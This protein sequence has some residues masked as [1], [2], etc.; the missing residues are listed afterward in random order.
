MLPLRRLVAAVSLLALL[1]GCGGVS[2]P[3]VDIASD[4]DNDK[5]VAALATLLDTLGHGEYAAAAGLMCPD[6]KPSEADLRA[7]F[8]PHARPWKHSV[9]ATSR[10]ND[11]GSGNFDLTPSGQSAVKYT[12]SYVKQADGS[13]QVCDVQRGSLVVDVD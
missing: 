12:F 11:S 3:S 4:P 9:T 13:W 10:S 1:S 2:P 7:E 8:E 5:V 6:E